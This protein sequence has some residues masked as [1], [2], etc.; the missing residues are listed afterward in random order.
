MAGSNSAVA[1]NVALGGGWEAEPW[2]NTAGLVE[3][4]EDMVR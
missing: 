4:G 3:G 2:E 1:R